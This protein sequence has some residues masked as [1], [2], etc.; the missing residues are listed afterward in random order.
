[1]Q[2]I[3]H[4]VVWELENWKKT[5]EAKFKIQLKQQ[6]QDYLKKIQEDVKNKDSEKD[7]MFR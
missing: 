6:E 4:Q 5:E 1:M 7:K 3:E 2:N